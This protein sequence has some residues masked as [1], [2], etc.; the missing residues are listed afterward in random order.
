MQRRRPG[1]LVTVLRTEAVRQARRWSTHGLRFGY[2]A[3][4]VLV[5]GAMWWVAL[6]DPHME[7]A[8]LGYRLF[9][10]YRDLLL[11]LAVGLAPLL[12][13]LGGVEDRTDGSL[14]LIALS[15]LQPGWVLVGKAV[16]RLLALLVVV[17]G[18]MPVVCLTV[19]MGGVAPWQVL[20]ATVNGVMLMVLLGSMAGLLA[21]AS[22]RVF[23]PA[24]A[25]ATW[26]WLAFF[27]LP[28]LF[29]HA[30]FTEVFLGWRG[31]G[32]LLRVV[33][34]VWAFGFDLRE[35]TQYLSPVAAMGSDGPS[36]LLP[37]GAGA[38]ALLV[39]GAASG[40]VLASLAG[41]SR[42]AR[43]LRWLRL[44]GVV[45]LPAGVAAWAI[46]VRAADEAT[47]RLLITA[48]AM[49]LLAAGTALYLDLSLWLLGDGTRVLHR[50]GREV[51]GNPVA[52]REARRG[53]WGGG[54]PWWWWVAGLWTATMLLAWW[55]APANPARSSHLDPSH[56]ML[57]VGVLVT[58]IAATTSIASEVTGGTLPLLVG[59]TLPPRRLV[60]G[61]LVAAATYSLPLLVLGAGMQG[62]RFLPWIAGFWLVLAL[63]CMC[64]TLLVRPLRVAWSV[65]VVVGAVY[66]V[67][68][69]VAEVVPGG[70]RLCQVV[71]PPVVSELDARLL[72]LSTAALWVAGGLLFALTVRMI[73]RRGA[74]PG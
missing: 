66:L 38:V 52:W 32:F 49:L 58:I 73:D 46:G 45:G 65:N 7:T 25:A 13:A 47:A 51:R 28:M 24:L 33:E 5:I 2:G 64:G 68:V 50:P 36:G 21:T 1:T 48:G 63:V 72:L 35:G 15:G 53:G 70:T 60:H 57:A 3:T 59:S 42:R 22:R 55:A 19:A 40:P 18:G 61:K 27:L 37:S 41:A 20:N 16:A 29:E 17:L 6:R 67:T 69:P 43:A 8:E 39:I 34:R 23:G 4:L 26:G 14:P 30:L 54:A 10:V 44:L 62:M 74:V 11:L 9:R 56:A 71:A 31:E 12:V